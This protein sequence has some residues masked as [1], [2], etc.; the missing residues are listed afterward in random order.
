M[1]LEE[2]KS[3]L[4]ELKQDGNSEEDILKILYLMYVDGELELSDFRTFNELM[5]YKLTDEF[6]AMSEE[7]KKTKGLTRSGDEGIS[8]FDSDIPHII[9]SIE[10]YTKEDISKLKALKLSLDDAA[11]EMAERH[12]RTVKESRRILREC[13]AQGVSYEEAIISGA[14]ITEGITMHEAAQ[15]LGWVGGP[16]NTKKGERLLKMFLQIGKSYAQ[17]ISVFEN[18]PEDATLNDIACIYACEKSMSFEEARRFLITNRIGNESYLDVIVRAKKKEQGMS[19]DELEKTINAEKNVFANDNDI[20][21]DL[22]KR[23]CNNSIKLVDLENLAELLGYQLSKE[24]Q[25]LPFDKKQT[26]DDINKVFCSI[27][28]DKAARLISRVY[29]GLFIKENKM[30]LEANLV[31]GIS[32]KKTLE[33]YMNGKGLNQRMV[34]A[35]IHEHQGQSKEDVCF[36]FFQEYCQNKYTF[37]EFRILAYYLGYTFKDELFTITTNER[38]QNGFTPQTLTEEWLIKDRP[39]YLG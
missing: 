13:K 28:L 5:G 8:K 2:A 30:L 35:K 1:T 26:L 23:Y 9:K 24:F 33:Q 32:Y 7:D 6:E 17:T 16:R 12:N 27:S 31:D 11:R 4:E 15:R 39:T 34:F 29:G 19:L 20:L 3:A 18:P 22:Y 36:D 25:R 37:G 10:N 38:K 14:Y 21:K